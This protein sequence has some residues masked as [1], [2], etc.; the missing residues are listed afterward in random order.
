MFAFIF[1]SLD[2]LGGWRQGQESSTELK[3]G[4]SIPGAGSV[5]GVGTRRCWRLSYAIC[6]SSPVTTTGGAD[7]EP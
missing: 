2:I 3:P 5:G 6:R 1:F 4:Q 7:G